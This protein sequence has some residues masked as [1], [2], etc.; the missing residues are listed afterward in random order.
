MLDNEAFCM[1]LTHK[2]QMVWMRGKVFPI[3]VLSKWMP[4]VEDET[5]ISDLT[6]PGTHDSPSITS[7]G[8]AS[9]QLMNIAQQLNAGI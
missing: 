1:W 3:P 2:G 4:G 9:T 8:I 6:I 7:L 5:L